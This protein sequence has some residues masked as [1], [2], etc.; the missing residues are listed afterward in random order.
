MSGVWINTDVYTSL[1]LFFYLGG[2]LLWG[3]GYVLVIRRIIKSKFVEVP[4]FA[5]CGNITWEFLWGFYFETD[6]GLLLVWFY[7]LG[8]LLDV[9]ILVSVFLYGRKQLISEAVSK[10]FYPMVVGALIIWTCMYLAFEKQGYDLPLG[11][12]S[13]YIVNLAMSILYILL[14]LNLSNPHLLSIPIGWLKGLG[15]GM[16]TVF[17]FLAYPDNLFVQVISVVV[18]VLDVIYMVLLYRLQAR[19]PAPQEGTA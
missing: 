12:N 13:A 3:I 14:A 2:F 19:I 16:V 8:A 5:V 4:V 11:S 15:T 17:V 18:G 7:R 10:H 1:Q 6:M 9:G